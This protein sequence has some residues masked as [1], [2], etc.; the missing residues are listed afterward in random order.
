VKG[1]VDGPRV[2]IAGGGGQLGGA[3]AARL[4]GGAFRGR[5]FVPPEADLDITDPQAV[6]ASLDAFRPDWVVNC[7]A[8]TA[9]D[10]AETDSRR[11]FLVNDE[12]LGVLADAAHRRGARLLHL[13]TDY[14]FDGGKPGNYVEED[15]TA[16]LNVYG[17]SKL[18]GEKRLL[19]HPV[20]SVILRTAWLYG[21]APGK[22]FL[23]WVME[24]GRKALDTG[25][26][27]PL[28]TDQVGSPTDVHTLSI[29]IEE[30]IRSGLAGLFHAAA[31]GEASWYEFGEEIF[32]R[33]GISPPL[34]PVRGEDL[35]RAA[36]RPARVVL[37]NRRLNQLGKN[38]MIPWKDGLRG[39]IERL[40]K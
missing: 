7:A 20:G 40:G 37:E 9:V 11:A 32:R 14:V 6:G 18:A 36:K 10:A 23:R 19:A 38:R 2:L 25:V 35:R 24:A 16:P 1:A 31:D 21:E 27:V 13:S 4:D 33:L 30:A 39:V 8:Y 34:K 22:S 28:V 5:V 26:P 17:A 3:L 29:Q 12:A 15:A